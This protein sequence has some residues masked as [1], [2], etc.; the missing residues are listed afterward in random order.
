MTGNL[1]KIEF[2]G[3]TLEACQSG[4]KVW[5]SLRRLCECIGVDYSKQLRKLKSKSWACVAQRAMQVAG[6]DQIRTYTLIDIETVLMWLAGIDEKRVAEHVRPKLQRYQ[7]ECARVLADHFLKR[8]SPPAST[9]PAVSDAGLDARLVHID[10]I[11]SLVVSQIAQER[12]LADMASHLNDAGMVATAAHD[13]A[14]AGRQELVLVRQELAVARRESK[15]AMRAAGAAYRHA[16]AGAG[17]ATVSSDDDVMLRPT[18]DGLYTVVAWLRANG[19][20]L[21]DRP[22]EVQNAGRR[23]RARCEKLKLPYRP[24]LRPHKHGR[25]HDWINVYHP[26][27]IRLAV[28]GYTTSDFPRGTGPATAAPALPSNPGAP[29]GQTNSAPVGV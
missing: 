28:E 24:V 21:P 4:D 15:E 23:S 10:L 13:E 12:Q 7:K 2:H 16:T 8:P 29:V 14:I 22:N 5:T 17:G 20:R 6:D 1:V 18:A 27:A 11:R 9:V 19:L 25:D 26:E 3:D